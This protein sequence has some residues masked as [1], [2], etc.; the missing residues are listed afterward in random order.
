MIDLS[1]A[2]CFLQLASSRNTSN[3]LS[4]VNRSVFFINEYRNN[5]ANSPEKEA[6][7]IFSLT[8]LYYNMGRFFAQLKVNQK[9]M[10]FFTKA[11][12]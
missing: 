1:L 10:Q 12:K 8:Q 9:A 7:V 6:E 4:M 2:V 3:K 11:I 5:L